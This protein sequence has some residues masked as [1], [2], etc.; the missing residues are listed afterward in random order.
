MTMPPT[1]TRLGSSPA[2]KRTPWVPA[3]VIPAAIMVTSAAVAR[4][5]KNGGTRLLPI[6]QGALS[7]THPV[8]NAIRMTLPDVVNSSDTAAVPPAIPTIETHAGYELTSFQRF[9]DTT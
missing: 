1:A 5:W 9:A 4:F 7:T 6:T 3:A 2:K 8:R